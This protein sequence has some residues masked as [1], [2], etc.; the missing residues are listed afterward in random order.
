VSQGLIVVELCEGILSATEALFRIGIKIQQLYVCEIDPESGRSASKPKLGASGGLSDE[1]FKKDIAEKLCH[2]CHKPGHQ[3]KNC[4]SG[5]KG[6][7]T[8]ASTW[9]SH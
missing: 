9:S 4:P 1:Q 5:R 7:V 2:K 8:A 3:A 6:K